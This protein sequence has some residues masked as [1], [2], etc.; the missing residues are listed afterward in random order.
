MI[1]NLKFLI[2]TFLFFAAFSIAKADVTNVVATPTLI[3]KG[4]GT[5][6][7]DFGVTWNTT[8]VEW[9]DGVS[10]TVS[11]GGTGTLTAGN[12]PAGGSSLGPWGRSIPSPE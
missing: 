9:I 2:A 6:D 10:V 3:D 8:N 12:W 11:G 4:D 1:K 7:L 5:F